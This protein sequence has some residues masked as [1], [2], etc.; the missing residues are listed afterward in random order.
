MYFENMRAIAKKINWNKNLWEKE[1]RIKH[2]K[3][4]MIK[5]ILKSIVNFNSYRKKIEITR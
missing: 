5:Q 1:V 4:T 2:Y 3:N